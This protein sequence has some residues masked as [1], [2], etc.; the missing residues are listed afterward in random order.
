MLIPLGFSIYY[1]DDS[2]LPLIKSIVITVIAGLLLYKIFK[3][4]NTDVLHNREGMAIVTLCWVFAGFFG[5]LPFYFSGTCGSF[6]NA[7]FESVS[8]FTTTGASILSNIEIIPRGLLLWRSLIQWLGGMGIIVLS[9]ALLPMLGIG[10]MQLYKAEVPTP[11]PD[12]LKPHIRD[13]AKVLWK[14]YILMSAVE[15]TLL[16]AG[17]MNFFDA[18]CHTFTTMPT[19]GFSTKNTSIAHFNSIYFD[20]VIILFMFFAGINFSLH[21]QMLKGKPLAFWKDEEFRVFFGVTLF[22]CL[23]VSFNLFGT[24]YSNFFES[25]RFGTFQVMSIITTTGL[26]TADFEKWPALSQLILILCMFL[27]ASA[28]STGGGIKFLRIILLFKYCLRE[29]FI[30]LHPRAVAQIKLGNRLVPDNIMRSIWG[31]LGL[32]IGLFIL[33]TLILAGMGV[34]IITSFTSVASCIGNIGPGLGLVG[35]AENF[36]AIPKAGKLVLIWCMLIGR[37]E[38]YT[39]IILFVPEF[40]RK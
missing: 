6:L 11:V 35:P 1:H 14:V 13:T 23:I 22:F 33:C 40:W 16:F 37:L 10:G 27:G 2:I 34:D 21:Y 29:L 9:L 15:F 39:V 25:L 18:I 38:I 12:K 5:A 24:V 8:G 4:S 3:A 7:L 26:A 28:G 31:F 30:L 36:N 17:G 20:I 19:G 32:Y